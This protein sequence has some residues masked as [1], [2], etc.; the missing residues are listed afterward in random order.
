[1]G[2]SRLELFARLGRVRV[3][4]PMAA[5]AY[6]RLLEDEWRNGGLDHHGDSWRGSMRGSQ[7]PGDDPRPCARQFAYWLMDIP[8]AEPTRRDV[9]GTAYVGQAIEDDLIKTLGFDGRVLSTRPYLSE[10]YKHLGF[11]DADHW[12][13]ATPDIVVLPPFWHR[14]HVV[15]VKSKDTEVINDMQNGRRL[16]DPGHRLQAIAS[17][18]LLSEIMA[19]EDTRELLFPRVHVCRHTWRLADVIEGEDSSMYFCRDHQDGLDCLT[20]IELGPPMT[21]SIYYHSLERP[22]VTQEWFLELPDG[23][24]ESGRRVLRQALEHFERRELPQ[25]PFGGKGWSELP[26]KWCD[27]KKHACKPDHKAG[28]TAMEESNGIAFAQE[29][30]PGYDFEAVHSAVIERWEGKSGV[31]PRRRAEEPVAA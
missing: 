25:H 21:A 30:R 6:Q 20:E 3:V 15:E 13:T 2:L 12:L 22:R 18:G 29:I 23:F 16:F 1:M 5:A 7:F 24:M 17:L 8:E 19:D 11:E 28:I 9:H 26:C 10:E 14:P 31:Y 4:E 27:F